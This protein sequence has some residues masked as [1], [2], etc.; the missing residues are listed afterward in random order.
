MTIDD[1]ASIVAEAQVDDGLNIEVDDTDGARGRKERGER[2]DDGVE[3]RLHHFPS[4]HWE[5][6]GGGLHEIT[7]S[8]GY[9]RSWTS[10]KRV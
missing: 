3:I 5:K 4:Q 8:E 1:P 7:C 2:V 6:R 9:L 10:C